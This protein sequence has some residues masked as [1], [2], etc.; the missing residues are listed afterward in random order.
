MTSVAIVTG[1]GR[2][3]GAAI[4]LR[5]AAEGWAVVAVDRC[6]DIPAIPY[7]LATVAELESAVQDARAVAADPT[8]IRPVIADARNAA[9]LAA[10]IAEAE[11][12]WGRL[13]AA[14]AVAGV[15][16]GGV[17]LWEMPVDQVQEVLEVDLAAVITL[18][19]VAVPALLRSPQPRTGRFLALSSTAAT[20]GLPMLAA[21]GAAKAGVEALV[22]GLAA[23]LAGTGVTANAIRPGS[24]ETAM[25]D[26]SAR[27]YNLPSATAFATQQH[28]GRLLRPDEVAAAVLWLVGPESSG[29]TG[30]VIPVDGGFVG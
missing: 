1:A 30:A 29:M 23:D 22:R 19:Q 2:G 9:A 25:L 6:A 16:A 5:L 18:A 26:Q 7:P 21:Y 8:L 14:V 27:L 4:V 17:P 3:I 20:N 28:V 24:T 15:V 10:A 13:D 12:I 11:S